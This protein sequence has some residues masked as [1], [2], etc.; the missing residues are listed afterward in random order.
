MS[1]SPFPNMCVPWWAVYPPPTSYSPTPYHLLKWACHGCSLALSFFLFRVIIPIYLCMHVIVSSLAFSFFLF[2]VTIPMRASH[3]CS[4]AFSFFLFW[5]TIPIRAC[6]GK[7]FNIL[8][9]I[10]PWHHTLCGHEYAV[11]PAPPSYS[12]PPYPSPYAG[13]SLWAV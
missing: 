4:I 7:Q 10:I 3:G 2:W 11:K 9:I 8:L 6:H 13:M 1:P 12:V 5:V